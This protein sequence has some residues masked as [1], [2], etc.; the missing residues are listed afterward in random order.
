MPRRFDTQF[1]QPPAAGGAV[2]TAWLAAVRTWCEAGAF[3]R[4]TVPLAV[5]HIAPQPGLD[6]LA[7]EMDGSHALARLGRWRGLAWR[8]RLQWQEA[9]RGHL[10]ARDDPWDCG[11][12]RSEALAHAAGFAPRRPTLLLLRDPAP[13]ARDALLA[14][15]QA[16]SPAYARPLRVLLVAPAAPPGTPTIAAPHPPGDPA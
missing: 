16:R 12:W 7:A 14:T 5:A 9:Q 11:W 1:M 2:D 4:C 15:L 8:L 10:P 13:A 3:P 6:A